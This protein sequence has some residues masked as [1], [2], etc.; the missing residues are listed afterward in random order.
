MKINTIHSTLLV[1]LGTAQARLQGKSE[2]KLQSSATSTCATGNQAD[3]RGTVTFTESGRTCQRWD[4]QDPHSHSRTPENYPNA[5]LEEN[6]CRNPDGEPKAWCYTTDPDKRWE[7]CD[8]PTCENESCGTVALQQSDYR[9]DISET[10]DG[11]ECQAWDAQEPHSHS[12]TPEN[13]PYSGLEEN[14]C[15]NPDGEPRAWCY[16]T[17]PNKRWD[18]CDVPDC[19]T[20]EDPLNQACFA[21]NNFAITVEDGLCDYQDLIEGL[22][23]KID[24]KASCQ[25]SALQELKYLMGVTTKSAVKNRIA[26]LCE[27]AFA[28]QAENAISLTNGLNQKS[29][30]MEEYFDGGTKWNDERETIDEDTGVTVNVLKED[31]A[32]VDALYEN[33]A[34]SKMLE[35]PEYKNFDDCGLDAVYCCWI[36]DRQANDNN[37]GCDTPYD[38]NCVDEDPGDNTDVCYVDMD[39]SDASSHVAG[40]FS[41]FKNGKEGDVHCHGF[42]WDIDDSASATRFRGNNLFYVSLYDHMYTRGYVRSVPGAPMCGCAEQ[43]PV[44]TRADCTEM[45][46]T[47]SWKFRYT[48]GVGITVEENGQDIAYNACQGANNNNNDLR[49]YYQRLV[50][51]GRNKQAKLDSLDEILVG[52]GNCGDA[53]ASFLADEGF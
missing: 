22:Q 11:L 12:R 27:E 34:Q 21:D 20:A 4:A 23:V 2:R 40:G 8:I 31:A 3:Y 47:E 52:P 25:H 28:I 26:V 13:Y 43:M 6:Y 39:R 53:I 50:D 37:G 41:I 46:I 7:F 33:R 49:A 15:R 14:Y 48:V 9:G 42:A 16:T 24:N 29:Y 35:M 32:K 18:Y 44:V 17:N 10:Q 36:Q 45:D 1:L 51:E 30:F 38:D 5:G 19:N